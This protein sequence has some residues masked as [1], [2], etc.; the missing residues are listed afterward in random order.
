MRCGRA[1]KLVSRRIDGL[2]S[3]R[4]TASLDR[5]L[6]QC[7]A[8]RLGTGQLQRAWRA[9][10]PLEKVDAAPDDWARIEAA[11]QATGGKW[12]WRWPSWQLAPA[13]AAAAWTFAGMVALGATAGVLVSR[14]ALAP[15]RSESV[16]AGAFAETLGD[17]PWGSPAAPLA[18]ALDTE[19]SKEER[20]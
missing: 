20:P 1:Q 6:A 10:A 16:E 9:L 13:P 18:L 19:P 17:L 8:C 2:L 14:A 3:G 11:V 15:V 5:H 12:A 4:D 7:P